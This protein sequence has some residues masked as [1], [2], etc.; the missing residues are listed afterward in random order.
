MKL[1]LDPQRIA[2]CELEVAFVVAS[3]TFTND[4]ERRTAAAEVRRWFT[5]KYGEEFH[6]IR[7]ETKAEKISAEATLQRGGGI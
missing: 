1:L 3:P 5:E 4:E 2:E 6:G 7:G